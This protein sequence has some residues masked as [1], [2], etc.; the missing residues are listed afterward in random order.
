MANV[1]IVDDNSDTVHLCSELLELAGYLVTRGF[2]GQEGLKA[3]AVGPL[4]DCILLDV[5]MPVLSGPEMVHLM[6]LHGAGEEKIPV[7]LVSGRADLSAVARRVGTPYFLAKGTYGYG[8]ALLKLL[9]R[10]L[11]ERRAPAA[12]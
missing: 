3:L 1:L 9:D 7:V 8:D 11:I 6:L 2:N 12:A 5:D 10:A 4:P